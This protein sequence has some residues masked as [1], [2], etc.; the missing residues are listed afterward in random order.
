MSGCMNPKVNCK[1]GVGI[2]HF[3]FPHNYNLASLLTFPRKYKIDFQINHLL[4]G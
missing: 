4:I 3:F 1:A 2:L